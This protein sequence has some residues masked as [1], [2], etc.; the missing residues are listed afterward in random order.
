MAAI[1]EGTFMQQG[2]T[3]ASVAKKF[4][5]RE[6]KILAVQ[7]KGQPAQYPTEHGVET[8]YDGDFVVQVGT[9]KR[10]QTIAPSSTKDGKRVPGEI[11]DVEE[12]L[13]EVIKAE[14]FAKLYEPA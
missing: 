6:G 8:A 13:L 2:R 5:P 14:D 11:H 3:F 12:P 10:Q 1:A 7:H 4:R 9:V